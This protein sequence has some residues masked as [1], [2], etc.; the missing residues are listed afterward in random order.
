MHIVYC[1]YVCFDFYQF[2]HKEVN[3]VILTCLSGFLGVYY[4]MAFS[5]MCV[6]VLIH[7]NQCFDAYENYM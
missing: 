5:L 3:G 7:N 4:T 6:H 2:E 1:K